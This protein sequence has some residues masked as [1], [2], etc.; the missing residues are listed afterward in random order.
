MQERVEGSGA[1]AITVMRQFLHHG[2]AKDGLVRSMRKHVNPNKSQKD[3]PLLFQH[4][5]NIPLL[6][7][8][9]NY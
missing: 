2:R 5:I 3:I 7:R 8:F 6:G 9:P 4:N 1:N